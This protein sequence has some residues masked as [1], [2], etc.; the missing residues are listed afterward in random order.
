MKN[1]LKDKIFDLVLKDA[2][3]DSLDKELQEIDEIVANSPLHEFSPQ[4][5][6]RMKKTYKFHR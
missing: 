4:F 1:E 6:K 3:Q 2:L 5:E